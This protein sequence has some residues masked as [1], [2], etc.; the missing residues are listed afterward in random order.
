M[1]KLMKKK[2]SL[3]GKEVSVFA[4]VM[5]AMIGLVSAALVGY[6]SNGITGD[7]IVDSPFSAKIASGLVTEDLVTLTDVSLGS[8]VGG[9]TAEATLRFQY[10]GTQNDTEVREVFTISNTGVSCGDFESI[11]FNSGNGWGDLLQA[12]GWCTD[13]G[14]SLTITD[15]SGHN[16]YDANE[17]NLVQVKLKFKLNAHGTYDLSA[18]IEPMVLPGP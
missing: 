13:N 4:I 12:G 6:V 3:L 7:V 11:E 15:P 1:K 16:F 8:I 2:V 10:L 9:E 17:I 18:I 14:D 5:V